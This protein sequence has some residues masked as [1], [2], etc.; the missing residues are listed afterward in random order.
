MDGAA[1]CRLAQ[2]GSAEELRR[3][4]DALST[5]DA[6]RLLT[7]RQRRGVHGGMLPIHVAAKH[8]SSVSAMP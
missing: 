4:L 8:N 3:A 5:D 7:T 2:E 1:F 6:E